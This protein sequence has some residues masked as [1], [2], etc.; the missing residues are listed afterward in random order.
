[1][2][3]ETHY[4]NKWAAVVDG[5]SNQG[6]VL[7]I[8]KIINHSKPDNDFIYLGDINNM[9]SYGIDSPRSWDY[10]K[11]DD[12]TEWVFPVDVRNQIF[13]TENQAKK[14]IIIQLFYKTSKI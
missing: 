13:D 1:M 14:S 6:I 2:D 10:T 5:D 7:H 8:C 11:F 9:L 4:Q 3:R 12:L